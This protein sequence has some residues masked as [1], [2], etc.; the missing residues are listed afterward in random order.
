M[1]ADIPPL[2]SLGDVTAYL[3]GSTG[4]CNTAGD[5]LVGLG[6][7]AERIKVERFGPSG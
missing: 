2:A 5:L 3:C 6:Q 4:F 1:A 7:P